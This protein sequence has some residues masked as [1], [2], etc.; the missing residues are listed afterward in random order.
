MQTLPER[1]QRPVEP[2]GGWAP[3]VDEDE[4]SWVAR[5]LVQRHPGSALAIALTTGLADAAE[6]H[7]EAGQPLCADVWG[8]ETVIEA[9]R[10]GGACSSP[11]GGDA[12]A[13]RVARRA[14]HY[15]WDGSQLLRAMPGGRPPP[16][17]RRRLVEMM[18]SRLGHLGVRRTLALLQLGHWC[19]PCSCTRWR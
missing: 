9:L 16:D 10:A 12:V 4:E 19:G 15:R 6:G 1:L 3:R 11:P 17:S 7:E 5:A 8:D 14:A 2:L 13:R 18:H